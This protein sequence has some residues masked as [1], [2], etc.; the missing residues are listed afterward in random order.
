MTRVSNPTN[1]AFFRIFFSTS[2]SSDHGFCWDPKGDLNCDPYRS[3][4]RD[5][6]DK[7][8]DK[9]THV[10]CPDTRYGRQNI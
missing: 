6:D 4:D 10:L 5:S 7:P 1:K 2:V 8:D 3:P 9:I